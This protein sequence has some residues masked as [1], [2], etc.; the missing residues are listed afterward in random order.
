MTLCPTCGSEVRPDAPFCRHCGAALTGLSTPA[1]DAEQT[2]VQ[3]AVEPGALEPSEPD[4]PDESESAAGPAERAP[5]RTSWLGARRTLAIA[6][7]L[8]LLA[9]AGGGILLGWW[10]ASDRNLAEKS[11]L[12]S[13]KPG[14]TAGAAALTMPDLRGIDLGSS[15]QILADI[16]VP[17]SSVKVTQQPAAGETGV[18]LTQDPVYGYDATGAI[19]LVVSA[20]AEVPTIKGKQA[21]AV[22]SE[23]EQL[24]AQVQTISRYVPGAAT[25]E[26]SSIQP[27][28]GSPLPEKVRVVIATL[29]GEVDLTQVEAVDGGG[30]Y[31]TTEGELALNTRTFATGLTCEPYP[32][33]ATDQTYVIN[34]G[35]DTVQGVLGIPNDQEP[36]QLVRLQVLADGKVVDTFDGKYGAL[37]PFSVKVTGA[38][39]I[40]LRVTSRTDDYS[41]AGIGGLKVIGD[42]TTLQALVADE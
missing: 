8:L 19:N 27:A 39:R 40:T 41:V 29:P 15:R 13:T 7:C 38:L 26:I 32:G 16:G 36:S 6:G 42:P 11:S 4:Q 20:K 12:P 5:R 3:P 18:V 24:G 23:L 22:L 2:A 10:L 33:E 34:R 9:V 14:P 25:G 30:C 37:T 31:T 1:P 21:T 17:P 28:P 35:G